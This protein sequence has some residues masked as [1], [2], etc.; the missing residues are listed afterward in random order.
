[1]LDVSHVINYILS[2]S[3]TGIKR[4]LKIVMESKEK[5]HRLKK[6]RRKR[7][8]GRRR[9]K[10]M[11]RRVSQAS[12][13][14]M[15]GNQKRTS[16]TV[17][18]FE[19]SVPFAVQYSFVSGS[20]TTFHVYPHRLFFASWSDVICSVSLSLSHAKPLDSFVMIINVLDTLWLWERIRYILLSWPE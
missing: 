4:G 7:E 2:S 17:R 1:M 8:R 6:M 16:R 13:M 14:K 20:Y 12:A 18:I 10:S 9:E 15:P 5:E 11:T 3:I 19:Y